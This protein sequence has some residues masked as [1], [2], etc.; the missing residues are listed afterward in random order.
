MGQFNNVLLAIDKAHTVPQRSL[1]FG[2]VLDGLNKVDGHNR[3][4]PSV[5]SICGKYINIFNIFVRSIHIW[6]RKLLE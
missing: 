2:P 5:K 6:S 1:E 3:P 4:T